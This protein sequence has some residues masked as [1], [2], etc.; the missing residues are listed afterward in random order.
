MC[1]WLAAGA[2]NRFRC[3]LIRRGTGEALRL[4]EILRSGCGNRR[5]GQKLLRL[6]LLRLLFLERRDFLVGAHE[7][8]RH[9]C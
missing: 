9:S 8:L 3:D 1:Y 2:G 4:R 5:G 7:A 6:L